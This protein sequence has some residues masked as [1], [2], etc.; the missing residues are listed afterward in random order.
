MVPPGEISRPPPV[1]LSLGSCAGRAGT[2]SPVVVIY[3]YDEN[4]FAKCFFGRAP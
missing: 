3:K 4:D 2:A 1:G